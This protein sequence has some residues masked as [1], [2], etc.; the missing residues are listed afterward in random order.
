MAGIEKNES[1]LLIEHA[2]SAIKNRGKSQ[3][4]LAEFLGIEP[5]RLSEGKKGN[6]RLMSSQKASIVRE[7]GYPRQ[8]RGVYIKAEHYTTVDKLIDSF[9]DIGNQRY[10]QRLSKILRSK[11]YLSKILKSVFLKDYQCKSEDTT[12]TKLNDYISSDDF[13]RWFNSKDT[14]YNLTTTDAW[15]KCG[16]S[17]IDGY[18]YKIISNYLYRV[19]LLK[20]SRYSSYTIGNELNE[21]L[22][23]VEIVL[24]G[25]I[26]LDVNIPIRKN[27]Q[28]ESPI[29]IPSY[30]N[31]STGYTG[32]EEMLPDSWNMVHFKLFLSE[33]MRYNALISFE[34]Y[35]NSVSYLT[36]RRNIIIEDLDQVELF[37][38]IETIRKFLGESFS[39]EETIKYNIADNGGYVP[40]VRRL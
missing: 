30:Y 16:L 1:V 10:Y 37:Q 7:F 22:I 21:N 34:P 28:L 32:Y 14:P 15:D 12:R 27:E 29:S 2:I 33:S 26:I 5:S 38:E 18:E 36:N 35:E 24:S 31:D 11:D 13:Y 23:E 17:A 9:H 19:G 8:G 20:F 40:G 25:D 3:A 39:F 6:W 4:D